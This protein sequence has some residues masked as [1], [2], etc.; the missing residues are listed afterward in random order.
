[1]TYTTQVPVYVYSLY[2]ANDNRAGIVWAGSERFHIKLCENHAKPGQ[3]NYLV[4]L[5]QSLQT[6]LA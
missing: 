6:Q 3:L 5:F 4:Q 1:M 2:T